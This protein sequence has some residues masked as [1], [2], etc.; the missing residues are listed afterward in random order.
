MTTG[1][2]GSA[3][4]LDEA[5][6]VFRFGEPD[7]PQKPGDGEIGLYPQHIRRRVSGLVIPAQLRRGRG[8]P[9]KAR[10]V[11][12]QALRTRSEQLNRGFVLAGQIIRVPK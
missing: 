6:C 8:K 11:A 2:T 12:G 10:P 4:T 5:I 3:Q 9:N 7:P 1:R